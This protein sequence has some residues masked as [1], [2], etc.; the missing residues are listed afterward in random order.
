MRIVITIFLLVP[1]ITLAEDVL[2]PMLFDFKVSEC[3]KHSDVVKDFSISRVNGVLEVSWE[4][5][6]NGGA[7]VV[8]PRLTRSTKNLSLAVES[9]SKDVGSLGCLC[10]YEINSKIKEN[11]NSYEKLY[12]ILNQTVFHEAFIPNYQSQQDK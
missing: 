6:I 7:V 10:R 5:Y 9:A 2:P 8:N 11:G 4:V 12:V 1:L 3:L